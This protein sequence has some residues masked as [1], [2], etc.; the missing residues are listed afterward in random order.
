MTPAAADARLLLVEHKLEDM[1][2]EVVR[3]RQRMHDLETDRALLSVFQERLGALADGLKAVREDV[4]GI[5]TEVGGLRK[6]LVVFAVT[7]AG[8]A[9]AIAL[10]V[11]ISTGKVGG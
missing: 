10:S 9:I 8:S 6:T 7:V 1:E 11:L 4:K 2:D 3:M 5:R